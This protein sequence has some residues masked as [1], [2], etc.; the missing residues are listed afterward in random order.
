MDKVKLSISIMVSNSIGTIRKCMESLVPIL[1]TI[2]SELI[3]VDT[4]GS[5]GSIEIAKEYASK[6]VPF[7]WC[8]DFAKARNAG[9]DAAEGEWFVFLDDDEWFENVEEIISFFQSGEDKKYH[10][11]SYLI[12]NYFNREGTNWEDVRSCR[13]VRRTSDLR[14]ESPIH[15]VLVPVYG[16]EKVFSTYVH[17]YGY[18]FDTKEDRIKHANRNITLLEDVL[19]NP[20]VDVRLM[21]QLAQEYRCI[22]EYQKSEEV[23]LRAVEIVR[24]ME[25]KTDEMIKYAGWSMVNVLFMEREKKDYEKLSIYGKEYLTLPWIN[26]LTKNNLSNLLIEICFYKKDVERILEYWEIY[27]DTYLLLMNNVNLIRSEVVLN[28]AETL[29]PV[30][31]LS[32]CFLCFQMCMIHSKEE[33]SEIFMEKM[34]LHGL[35]EY[36]HLLKEVTEFIKSTVAQNPNLLVCCRNCLKKIVVG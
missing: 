8:N 16:P 28:Q 35:K 29:K 21:V 33:L 18:V 9:L 5:D 23:S 14:F 19:S 6:I 3:I 22:D 34:V 26:N 31:Y 7:V 11:A 27:E 30:L 25:T 13:M 12:R 17:H 15:E 24:N 10:S 1:N 2:S 32:S 4:K 20:P 36:P